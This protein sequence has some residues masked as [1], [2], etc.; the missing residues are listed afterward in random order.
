MLNSEYTIW[1][2]KYRPK[3]FQEIKGQERL[4]RRIEAMIG[5]K[6]LPHML[7]SG[8]PGCGKS[9]MAL[10]I[11]KS[12]YGEEYH[13]HFL[14]LNSSDD[15]GIN[16]IRE[17]IKDFAK[18]KA[19]GE[20]PFKLIFLDEADALTREA[21]HALRRTMETYS[22]ST[23]FILS[24]NYSSKIIDPL[25]SR[26]AVF[27][28]QPLK[29]E[30]FKEILAMISEKEGLTVED[31]VL[32]ELYLISHGD[33][34]KFENLLQSCAALN[35][36]V[37]VEL[38]REIASAT[39][40]RE[41]KDVVLLALAGNF[42]KGRELLLKTMLQQGLSGLD[43]VKQIQQDVLDLDIEEKRKAKLV[44]DCGDIEFRLVE[45]SDEFVQLCTLLARFSSP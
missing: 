42:I 23:R 9:T 32:R 39:T 1:I 36:T 7:F 3:T 37:T 11:A 19:M 12:L 6:N 29:E 18:I 14:E 34:R 2:E 28:F 27:R 38:V 24:V 25:L 4:V 45:G 16:V 5:Q 21:Q 31:T 8:P 20:V 13:R 15:R 17:T 40:P 10:V 22:S 35:K 41:I 43:V 26:C 44:E 33:V 30:D